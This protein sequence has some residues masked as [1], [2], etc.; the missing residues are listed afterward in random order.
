MDTLSLPLLQLGL[1]YNPIGPDGAKALSE[2]LKFHGN[3]DTLSLG[4]CQVIIQLRICIMFLRSVSYWV[5]NILQIGIKGAEYIA[6]ILN[7]NSTISNLDLQ[8]NG[9]R[10]EVCFLIQYI[11]LH[12]MYKH[13]SEILPHKCLYSLVHDCRLVNHFPFVY[14]RDTDYFNLF[15]GCQMPSSE[16]ESGQWSLDY[17]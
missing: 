4:W 16:L 14:F 1:G 8:A 17:S 12:K 13:L 6:D 7:Y 11:F 5:W 3:I 2:V 9:L 10:C 15:I